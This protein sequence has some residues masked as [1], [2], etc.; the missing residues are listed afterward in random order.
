MQA[1]LNPLLSP[2]GAKVAGQGSGGMSGNSDGFFNLVVAQAANVSVPSDGAKGQLAAFAELFAP[3]VADLESLVSD[4]QALVEQLDLPED[5]LEDIS[6]SLADLSKLIE[7]LQALQNPEGQSMQLDQ[8]LAAV[9]P[10]ELMPPV[11]M[12]ATV[13]VASALLSKLEGLDAAGQVALSNQIG[14]LSG[15][16][17]ALQSLMQAN[18]P[19]QHIASMTAVVADA[20]GDDAQVDVVP[21][22]PLFGRSV[23]AKNVS[24]KAQNSGAT[25][26]AQVQ[27][28]AAN[29]G[30]FEIPREMVQVRP[31]ELASALQAVQNTAE[32]TAANQVQ[33]S[34]RPDAPQA[35]FSQ[36]VIGQ[37]RSV[38]FQEGTTKVELNP[39]GLG[40]I[41]LELKTNSDGSLSV[42]V[43]AENAHVLNSLRQE[44]DLLAQI[45]G[46]SGDASV[47][48]QEFASEDGSDQRTSEGYSSD[49]DAEIA[50]ADDAVT[51]ETVSIGN[52]QLDL[53]T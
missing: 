26:L 39:R 4:F 27:S 53:M 38:D 30:Q 9:V 28:N 36:A 1:A 23:V 14:G 24:E 10:T 22:D 35:K 3:V 25:A 32:L 45:V 20:S 21:E 11:L 50:D 8:N 2:M 43:R 41:E 52:G 29:P 42:V 7:N 51:E 44:Q 6:A 48:F 46:Q 18:R 49:G 33:A 31:H 40:N 34:A 12:Q 5:L 13:A 16:V 17:N 19:I 15:I 37:L 47:D